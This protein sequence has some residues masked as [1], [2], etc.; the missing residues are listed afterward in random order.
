MK[1]IS[2]FINLFSLPVSMLNRAETLTDTR[3]LRDDSCL[4][5]NFLRFF[6]DLQEIKIC[7]FMDVVRF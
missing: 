4:Y 6:Y 7:G 3:E 5:H 1:A 2:I